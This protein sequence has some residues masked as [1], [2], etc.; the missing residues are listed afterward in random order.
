MSPKTSM[1]TL[2]AR[3]F[4]VTLLL[5]GPAALAAAPPAAP[6]APATAPAASATRAPGTA[7]AASGATAP[8]TDRAAT[9]A[10]APAAT[11]T[12]PAEQTAPE[13]P[14]PPAP[15]PA[16]VRR[17]SGIID[18]IRQTSNVPERDDF[19]ADLVET[20]PPA[21]P[22]VLGELDRHSAATWLAMIYALGGIGDPRAIPVLRRELLHQSGDV[23]LEVLYAL[24]L[25]GDPDA[26]VLA[27]RSTNATMSFTPEANAVDFIAGAIGRPALT[28]LLR[29]IPR[30]SEE[31]RI[32]GL[33]ALGT[34]CDADAVP[35]L[36]EWSR[37]PKA[38]DRRCALMALARIGDPR[39][40]SRIVEAL[41]DPDLQVQEAAVEGAGYLREAAAVPTLTSI[42]TNPKVPRGAR[43]RSRALW[44]LGLIGGSTAAA[45]LAEALGGAGADERVLIVQ[46]LGNTKEPVA[47]DALGREALG[48]AATLATTAVRALVAIPGDA[49][50]QKLL[51]VCG[52]SPVHEAGLEAAR[53]LVTRRDP[54][55]MPCVLKQLKEEIDR[56][57]GLD[58]LAEEVLANLPLVAPLSVA[59]SLETAAEEISAPA[60][61]HRLRDAAHLITIVQDQVGHPEK[62]GS[63]EPWLALLDNGTPTE[64]DMAILRMAEMGDPRAVEPLRNHFG[65]IDADRA[66]RIPAALGRIGSERATSFLV[67]LLTDDVYRVPSLGR[68]REEAARALASYS[69]SSAAA[70]A[71]KKAFVADRGRLFVP[72]MAFARLR[73][74]EAIPDLLQLKP[75][76]L[77]RRGSE[78]IVRHE[79]V[80]W[81]IRLLR[82]GREVPLE[83]IKDIR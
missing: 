41:A 9:A 75:L 11:L 64:V 79:K 45:A 4:F 78:Q 18:R 40:G 71:L 67:Q 29:E 37:Q 20:G 53:E 35:F 13:P 61:Q 69:K 14:A 42:L 5:S 52:E 59:S 21:L 10:R 39:A 24:A 48:N 47:V 60:L 72:L 65:R 22:L 43:L 30:R 51:E 36:L 73:G 1:A 54:R 80:N 17:V 58:P 2:R 15:T 12:N 6:A 83:E 27:M 70:D 46:A 33:G 56:R 3:T 82:S 34:L 32:A 8:A 50:R 31:A 7:P 44:S 62:A 55:A 76:L 19:I 23:Y 25:A 66:W 16:V 63:I 74:A 38:V 68:A 26:L 49:S 57:H 28:I 81:A 77:Q